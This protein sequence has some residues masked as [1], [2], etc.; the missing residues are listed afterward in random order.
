VRVERDEYD[1]RPLQIAL[2][3]LQMGCP[4]LIA[5]EGGRSHA[6][7]MRPAKPGAAYL[8]LKADVPIVPVGVTGVEALFTRWRPRVGLTV[9]QP[10]RLPPAR[11]AGPERHRRLDEATRAI[12]ARLAAVL[13]PEYRGVYG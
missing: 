8:A 3:L 2:R 9:G 13:P 4:V 11:L 7:G 12:M 10:F 1:R 5:P 6:P